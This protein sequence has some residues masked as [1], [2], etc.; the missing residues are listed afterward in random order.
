MSAHVDQ[1]GE[2]PLHLSFKLQGPE[3][4][5]TGVLAGELD[6][7]F[8]LGDESTIFGSLLVPD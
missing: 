5:S 6:D 2:G 4:M 3:E 1:N 7:L 8:T